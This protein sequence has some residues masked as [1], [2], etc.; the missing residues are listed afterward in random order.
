MSEL[1][2]S[3]PVR[4]PEDARPRSADQHEHGDP[5]EVTP[6]PSV[7]PPTLDELVRIQRHMASLPLHVGA[8]VDH[9]AELGVL[10]VRQRGAGSAINYAAMPRWDGGTWRTSLDRL[11]GVMRSEGSWP[12]LLLADRFDRP[13]GLD[14][15]MA[16]IGWRRLL[17]E[18]VLWVGHA[19][20]VPHLDPRLR[21]EAVQPRSVEDHEALERDI[22]GVDP[23]R[24]EARR[25][26]LRDALTTGGLRA[27]VVRLD[28]EAIAVA[29]VSQGV[30]V[31]GI[32]ALGVAR[33]WRGQGYGTLLAT[34]STRA[35][36]ATG[37]RI[38]WLSVEDDNASARHV[39]DK[40]GFQPAFGWS[41]W[42][43]PSD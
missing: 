4:R 35:G 33:A 16:S 36:M 7:A 23:A 2:P 11:A 5:A 40:L 30:G 9:D 37:N 27:F 21:F 31:A 25:R 38:V 18:S 41:R 43:A 14:E 32:Y 34:I 29:R 28:G 6:P 10:M 42:L 13:P 24:A 19:S 20:V 12:S 3:S 39:Y 17:G 15:A 22:F 1:R 8:S 26:E